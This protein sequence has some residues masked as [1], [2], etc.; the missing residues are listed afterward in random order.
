M[1][2]WGDDIIKYLIQK[3]QKIE[4]L[5]GDIQYSTNIFVS[6]LIMFQDE[7]EFII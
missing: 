4:M 7:S 6:V 5:E 1:V 2:C 3:P